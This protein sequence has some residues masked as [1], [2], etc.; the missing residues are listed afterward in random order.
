MIAVL[1]AI[2]GGLG[3][4][5]RYWIGTA[6]QAG[7]GPGRFPWGT[8]VVNVAGCLAVGVVSALAE[9]WGDLTAETRAF[10]VVG[11]LGGFT[12]FSA[13]ANETMY[14]VRTG[15][16]PLAFLNVL[17]SVALCLAAVWAGRGMATWW[18]R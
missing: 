8:L 16:T 4:V 17:A 9:R 13:F 6:V 12:T 15:A 1:V 14:S 2:G 11:V 3:A 18:A 10:L 5:L 7:V